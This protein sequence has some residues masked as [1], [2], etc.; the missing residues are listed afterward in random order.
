MRMLIVI[1][2]NSRLRTHAVC[3]RKYMMHGKSIVRLLVQDLHEVRTTT[4]TIHLM[5]KAYV[6]DS[7]RE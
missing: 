6:R 3:A 2:P 1:H 4:F 5:V 7:G